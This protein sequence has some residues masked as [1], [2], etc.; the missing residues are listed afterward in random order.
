M[1]SEAEEGREA[2]SACVMEI[3]GECDK[4][5]SRVREGVNETKGVD[6]VL[7]M[8]VRRDLCFFFVSSSCVYH[9]FIKQFTLILY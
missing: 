8:L 6:K 9:G 7:N 1:A 4:L 3:N 5:W 2:K